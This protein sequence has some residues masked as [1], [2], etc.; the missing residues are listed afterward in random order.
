MQRGAWELQLFFLR[1]AM[2]AVHYREKRI[3]RG[4]QTQVQESCTSRQLSLNSKLR[5]RAKGRVE[6]LRPIGYRLFLL[7]A[8]RSTLKRCAHFSPKKLCGTL[9][10]AI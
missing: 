2:I 8:K 6:M 5:S 9:F 7:T 4:V 3:C 10:G 1:G